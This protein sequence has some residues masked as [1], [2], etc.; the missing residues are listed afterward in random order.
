MVVL[1]SKLLFFFNLDPLLKRLLLARM[2][3][4]WKQDWN[5]QVVF[6]FASLRHFV[7]LICRFMSQLLLKFRF[8]VFVLFD[9]SSEK[10]LYQ[11]CLFFG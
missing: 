6:T 1:F 3:L 2:L 8:G 9:Y 11:S 10:H 7:L 5:S 4:E